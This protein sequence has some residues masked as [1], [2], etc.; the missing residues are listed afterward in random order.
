MVK[1]LLHGKHAE[2]LSTRGYADLGLELEG[3][4]RLRINVNRQRSGLKIC[5][6]L[7]VSEPPTV[8]MLGLPTEVHKLTTQHQGLV[9]ISGPNGHG[10]T[11]TMAALVDLFNAGKSVHIITVED[12]VERGR[13][14]YPLVPERACGRAARGP[15]RDRNRRAPRS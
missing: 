3:A 1:S 5:V 13:D 11:T 8:E 6:R 4:G 14:A 12:P 9:I 10:K 7:V 2:Q 15:G